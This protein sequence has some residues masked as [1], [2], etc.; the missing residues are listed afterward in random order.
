[1]LFG[2]PF[3]NGTA[4]FVILL[5]SLCEGPRNQPFIYFFQNLPHATFSLY[6][7]N[8]KGKTVRG[9]LEGPSEEALL[10]CAMTACT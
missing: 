1:M 4:R 6:R 2:R 9:L 10:S 7:H 5:A 3:W 8:E